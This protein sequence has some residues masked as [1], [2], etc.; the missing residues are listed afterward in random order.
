MLRGTGR[1]KLGAIA[2][3]VGYYTLG[4]PI[5]ISLMFAAKMGVL[6]TC[7]TLQLVAWCELCCE[8]RLRPGTRAWIFRWIRVGL[9]CTLLCL[10]WALSMSQ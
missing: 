2:N 4:F 8:Q 6:G 1:Q 9:D 7:D 10:G 5:G 3:A